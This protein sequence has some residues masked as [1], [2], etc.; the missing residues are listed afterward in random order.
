LVKATSTAKTIGIMEIKIT[1]SRPGVIIMYSKALLHK[2][3]KYW[4]L[5]MFSPASIFLRVL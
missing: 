1:S 2:D 4:T 5:E 3:L